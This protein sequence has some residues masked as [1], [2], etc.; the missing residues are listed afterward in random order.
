MSA[1]TLHSLADYRN[2][3]KFSKDKHILTIFVVVILV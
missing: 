3:I 2:R 1:P